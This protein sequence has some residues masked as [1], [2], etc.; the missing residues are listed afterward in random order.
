M[1]FVA[2]NV[3]GMLKLLSNFKHKEFAYPLFF[4]I[5]ASLFYPLLLLKYSSSLSM[6]SIINFFTPASLSLLAIA[7]IL[8]S[9][10]ELVT[11]FSKNKT[12]FLLA[13]VILIPV[14]LHF[15]I[16]E[17]YSFEDL[18]YGLSYLSIPFFCYLY[19]ESF[20]RMLPVYMA[21]L[22]LANLYHSALSFFG[23]H[24]FSG[25]AG[26]RNWNAAFLTATL[27]FA[28]YLIYGKM[29]EKGYGKVPVL[30]LCSIPV[31][32][33]L[34]IFCKCDSRGG[35]LALATVV[36][37]YIFMSLKKRMKKFFISALLAV[38]VVLTI[39]FCLKGT[40]KMAELIAEDVRLP[41]WEGTFNLIRDNIL[42]GVGPSRFESEFSSYCPV[43]YFL[44]KNVAVRNDHPHNH[45]LFFASSFG[46][47]A[48]AAWAF[49]LIYPIFLF[50]VN[51]NDEKKLITRLLFFAF[52]AMTIHAMLD[53]VYVQW[54]TNILSL[55]ILGVLWAKT[56]PCRPVPGGIAELVPLRF[57][58]KSFFFI[59]GT[60]F[61]VLALFLSFRTFY[62]SNFLR[63]GIIY[64]EEGKQYENA[65][66]YLG[67]ALDVKKTPMSIYKAAMNSFFKLGNPELTLYYLY[68]LNETSAP[69]IAHSSGFTGNI[70]CQQNRIRD[71]IPWLKKEN[72]H[73]PLSAGILYNLFNAYTILGMPRDAED[74]YKRLL[75][76][77]SLKGLKLKHLP[78]LL[79][80]P[81][82]DLCPDRIP[83]DSL[84]EGGA[85]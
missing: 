11:A 80:N 62:S 65:A 60:A 53:M 31:L 72:L 40:D 68:M 42:Y 32:I 36:L 39:F 20:E 8:L 82:F 33:S 47:F 74:S 4:L 7:F 61:A 9:M 63:N 64:D 18:L 28:L 43:E 12:P 69:N 85:N 27:P 29:K 81:E 78:L 71:G 34:Y 15:F 77:L 55:M 22:W 45:L 37:L 84:R 66:F 70:L 48:A 46:I 51:Y 24:E 52:L 21:I 76:A 79:E 25:I 17:Q 23:G 16:I 2:V 75:I 57:C 59:S 38:S 56:W 19:A 54:P 83:P 26:N 41:L 50:L 14:F 49:L 67:K 35:L 13:A 44:R 3:P 5:A 6:I 1:R 30:I 10:S 73:F 58:G